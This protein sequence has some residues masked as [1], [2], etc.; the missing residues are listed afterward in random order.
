[1]RLWHVRTS[2]VQS[3]DCSSC[4]GVPK[5]TQRVNETVQ[6]AHM[7]PLPTH[8][9]RQDGT[10]CFD[11]CHSHVRRPGGG[12]TEGETGRGR[13]IVRPGGEYSSC[14]L[15][16]LL[17]ASRAGAYTAGRVHLYVCMCE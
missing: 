8:L 10:L 1:M 11:R 17:I 4:Y 3:L 13:S 16:A 2:L 6:V 5:H 12:G 15:T 7:T 14:S 9:S